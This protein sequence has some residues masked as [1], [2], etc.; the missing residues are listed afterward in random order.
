MWRSLINTSCM[1]CL[2]QCL[3]LP[4]LCSDRLASELLFAKSSAQRRLSARLN[5]VLS[6]G[7]PA[8]SQGKTQRVR[9]GQQGKKE[10][11]EVRINE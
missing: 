1:P 10:R 9:E 6:P 5:S 11:K 7:L 2:R 3:L 8:V 4:Y